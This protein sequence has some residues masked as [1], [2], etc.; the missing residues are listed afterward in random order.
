[1]IYVL[2]QDSTGY[3]DCDRPVFAH[4]DKEVVEKIHDQIKKHHQGTQELAKRWQHDVGE[5]H[6]LMPRPPEPKYSELPP[7]PLV[8]KAGGWNNAYHLEYD[9]VVRKHDEEVQKE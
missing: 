4:H 6:K 3:D 7:K 8:W 9:E 2:V 1:M 5:I